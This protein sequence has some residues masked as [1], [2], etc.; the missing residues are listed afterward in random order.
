MFPIGSPNGAMFEDELICHGIFLI[1]NLGFKFARTGFLPAIKSREAINRTSIKHIQS[2]NNVIK[3]YLQQPRKKMVWFD[4]DIYVQQLQEGNGLAKL[5]HKSNS[6][7]CVN[8]WIC[9]QRIKNTDIVNTSAQT[10]SPQHFYIKL[11][12][13]TLIFIVYMWEISW[14][15]HLLLTRQLNKVLHIIVHFNSSSSKKK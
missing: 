10:P 12:L 11:R 14:R 2:N 6:I 7:K 13:F 1:S 5:H 4:A 8:H 3:T 9:V 15:D